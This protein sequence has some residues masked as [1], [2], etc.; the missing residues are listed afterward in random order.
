ML[1][2]LALV[3][4]VALTATLMTG[5]R[6]AARSVRPPAQKPVP[7]AAAQTLQ[8]ALR[9]EIQQVFVKPRL[10]NVRPPIEIAPGSQ[11]CFVGSSCSL[12]PCVIPV[13]GQAPIPASVA[14]GEAVVALAA[15]PAVA[16]PIRPNVSGCPPGSI[17]APRSAVPVSAAR[18]LAASR[19]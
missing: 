7:A 3:G 15:G 17:N 4:V 12:H 6:S 14:P 10:S 16:Q 18:P 9:Q 1:M 13:R 8:G 11:T 5:G 2:A 19:P